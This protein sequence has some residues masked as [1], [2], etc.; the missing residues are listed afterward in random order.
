MP[1]RPVSAPPQPVPAPPGPTSAPAVAAVRSDDPPEASGAPGRLDAAAVRRVWD[2][3]L[4][5]VRRKSQRAWA[6][7]RE[8]TV[9]EVEGD[10]LVLV[11]RHSVHATMLTGSPELLVDAVGEVLGGTWQIRCELGG[12]Q[13]SAGGRAAPTMARPVPAASAPADA[14]SAA[15]STDWPTPARLGPTEADAADPP[16][17]EVAPVKASGRGGGRGSGA[18]PGGAAKSK[19]GSAKASGRGGARGTASTGTAPG[20]GAPAAGGSPHGGSNR[21]GAGRGDAN[22]WNESW[23]DVEVPAGF[24]EFDPGDE[25]LDDAPAARRTSEEQALQ[26]LTEKLGAEK[27]GES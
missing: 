21:G 10:T 22:G 17:A 11:F 13:T 15:P 12:E 24:D 27:I 26:L 9:R 18:A 2:E 16:P 8:A 6:V 3:V 1:A 5:M 19:G 7:V 23:N 25:P 4:T 20:P 14:A